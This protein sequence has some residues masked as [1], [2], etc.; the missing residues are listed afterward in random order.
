MRDDKGGH[1]RH[2][3]DLHCG[4]HRYLLVVVDRA[5]KFLFAFPLAANITEPVA[6]LFLTFGMPY[7]LRS[8]P[9]WEFTLE[10]VN[11]VCQLMKVMLYH[12]P[13]DFPCGQGAVK[14]CGGWL[15]D[16]LA[17]LCEQ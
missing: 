1:I 3:I 7:F 6:K 5:T 14:R 11:H 17:D 2:E 15:H 4:Q 13:A 10:V 12:C 9:G 16:V 8:D